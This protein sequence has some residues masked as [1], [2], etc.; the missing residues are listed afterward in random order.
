MVNQQLLLRL[1]LGL[2]L[3]AGASTIALPAQAQEARRDG[4]GGGDNDDGSRTQIA[5]DF[6]FNSAISEPAVDSGGGGAL[7]VGQQFDLILVSLTPEFSGS[8]HAFEGD[9]ETTIY[10]G[11]LGGRLA[12]GKIIEPSI[13]AHLGV[14]RADGFENRIA[15]LL[16]LGAALDF[17]MLPL[18]DLGVHSAYNRMFP[19]DNGSSLS[20]L[21]LGIH[22]ALIL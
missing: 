6:D 22:A 16:D 13:F 8:Y 4:D 1:V 17:T 20:Y 15:P 3:A 5:V 7:R 14:A 10:A 11:V 9:T 21:T 2:I 19:R 12:V 18:I